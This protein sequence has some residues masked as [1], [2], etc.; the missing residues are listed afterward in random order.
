M[1]HKKVDTFIRLEQKGSSV[2]RKNFNKRISF[3]ANFA[4]DKISL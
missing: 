2:T 1:D 3:M 4:I